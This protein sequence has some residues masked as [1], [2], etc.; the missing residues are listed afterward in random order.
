[1]RD[2]PD[3]GGDKFFLIV[4]LILV[5]MGIGYA[6][7]ASPTRL[8]VAIVLGN[9]PDEKLIRAFA[10]QLKSQRVA[11]R[12]K[13]LPVNGMREAADALD[14]GRAEL[15]VV[16]TDVALPENGLTLAILRD[17]AAIVVTPATAGIEDYGSLAGKTLGIV[18]GHE[19]DTRFVK[20][21][22]A[23]F[24]L[25][26]PAVKI[27][28]LQQDQVV[29]ALKAGS[30][31]AVAMVA[32]PASPEGS[33]FV[34][35]I[36][37]EFADAIKILP[38]DNPESI[39]RGILGAESTTIP[40]GVWGG[41]P[42]LPSEDV[43]SVSVSYRLMA[44]SDISR[45]TAALVTES[46]FQMRARLAG[47]AKSAVAMRAPEMDTASNATSAALPNH[48]GAVD[49]FQREQQS[50]MDRYGDW[51]YLVALFGSGLISLIAGMRQRFRRDN[52][53]P[54][55]DVLDRLMAILADARAAETAKQLDDIT[56][57]LD[58]LL[59]VA[60]GHARSGDTG[61]RSTTALMLALDGAR[62]AVEH[63]RRQLGLATETILR[64]ADAIPRLVT[65]L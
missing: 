27:M 65:S 63:R 22:L 40:E 32:P 23:H 17:A 46:L 58:D 36:A 11:L 16:R 57:E 39:A 60:V 19:A 24:D 51:I 18:V 12:L 7:W 64:R 13:I 44:Q 34:R 31:D 14:R 1:M 30:I 59:A 2:E 25:A 20:Q 6:W 45:S 62:S 26:P 35:L 8:T 50:V 37:R 3:S 54:I 21:I 42:K 5:T 52:R 9:S 47:A 56:V 48:P 4:A 49:Y 53:S 38:V 55:D 61:S 29:A 15:A 10:T 43:K 41:R 33:G 28:P